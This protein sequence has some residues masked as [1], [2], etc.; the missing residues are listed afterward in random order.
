MFTEAAIAEPDPAPAEPT[1]APVEAAPV[2]VEPAPASVEPTPAAEPPVAD[3]RPT[4][5]AEGP[6][7]V[8]F[9]SRPEG[10]QV[11][12]DGVAVGRTPLVV[13][14]VRAGTRRVRLELAGHRT[15]ATVVNVEPGTRVRVGASLER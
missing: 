3:V 9:A 11:F 5:V 12:L 4:P 2:P 8:S 10:A 13:S 7:V 6:A 1:P 15:W 14:D